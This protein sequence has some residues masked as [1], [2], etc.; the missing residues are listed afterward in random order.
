M[1]DFYDL[2][3]ASEGLD[4]LIII[5]RSPDVPSLSR[6][7]FQRIV[8]ATRAYR[9]YKASLVELSDSDDD[10]GPEN[11]DAWLYEDLTILLKLW[12]RKREKEG[13]L[14]LIFEVSLL[15]HSLVLVF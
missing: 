5:L 6:P 7:Q 13:L 11:E 1:I 10:E 14:A 15:S 8:K 9:E 12:M 4:L 3:V 2:Q